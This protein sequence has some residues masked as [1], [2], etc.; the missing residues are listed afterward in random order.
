MR[1]RPLRKFVGWC[2]G[3]RGASCMAGYAGHEK[4]GNR[5]ADATS[6]GSGNRLAALS[7]AGF[8]EKHAFFTW[9]ATKA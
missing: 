8:A 3:P 2:D 4:A 6:C 1:G 7:V 5:S 9:P